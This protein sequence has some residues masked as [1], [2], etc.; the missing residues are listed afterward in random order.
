MAEMVLWAAAHEATGNQALIRA[1][2]KDKQGLVDQ[3]Q[4]Q[5]KAA[6]P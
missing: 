3:I 1:L 5:W 4:R 6:N 2:K